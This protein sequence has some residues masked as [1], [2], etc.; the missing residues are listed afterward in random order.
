MAGM[1]RSWLC[2]AALIS[3]AAGPGCFLGSRPFDISPDL[4]NGARLPPTADATAGLTVAL[5][6]GP[7]QLYVVSL[8]AGVWHAASGGS[9][10][11]TLHGPTFAASV[12]ADP[13]IPGHI[14]AGERNPDTA[15]RVGLWESQDGGASWSFRLN[16]L[17]FP[18]CAAAQSAAIPAI[19]VGDAGVYVA[20]PC[21]VAIRTLLDPPNHF[22]LH[23]QTT[24]VGSVRAF[25]TSRVNGT[26]R[27]WARTAGAVLFSDDLGSSWTTMPIPI[28]TADGWDT[29]QSL[30]QPGDPRD[31]YSIAA[32]G[33]VAFFPFLRGARTIQANVTADEC[34]PQAPGTNHKNT[35]LYARGAER[36]FKV[37]VL[38]SCDGS[39]L[40]GRRFARSLLVSPQAQIAR[41]GHEARVFFDDAQ[42]LFEATRQDA[43]GLL[44]WNQISVAGVHSDH[45]DLAANAAGDLVLASDGGVQT[46]PAGQSGWVAWNGGLHTQHINTFTVLE[47][48]GHDA[49]NL[50]VATADNGSWERSAA[51]FSAPNTGWSVSFGG[52]DINWTMGDQR[53]Y[54]FAVSL[55]NAVTALGT[56]FSTRFTVVPDCVPEI[57]NS[58]V[59]CGGK[60]PVGPLDFNLIQTLA[61]EPPSLAGDAYLLVQLPLRVIRQVPGS[62]PTIFPAAGVLGSGTGKVLL[63]NR[64]YTG[65]ADT[66]HAWTD[67]NVEDPGRPPPPGL[68]QVFASGGHTHTRYWGLDFAQG[69]LYRNTPGM[70]WTPVDVHQEKVLAVYLN[71]YDPQHLF[72]MTPNQVYVTV[73]GGAT[74]PPDDALKQLITSSLTYPLTAPDSDG[75]NALQNGGSGPQGT[76]AVMSSRANAFAT[77]SQIAFRP[78]HPHQVMVAAPQGGAFY[79]DDDRRIWRS[80]SDDLPLN[81]A[82]VTGVA[83]DDQS[84][85]VG[86]EGRGLFSIR[87]VAA[88]RLG[89][90]IERP[91]AQMAPRILGTARAADGT[92][93]AGGTVDVVVLPPGG[94]DES[95]ATV[96]T[97]AAGQ[98]G[99][100]ASLPLPQGATV[101]LSVHSGRRTSAARMTYTR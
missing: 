23:P 17:T 80:I 56:N 55:R 29:N 24:G 47:H 84:G 5:S 6:Q 73:D 62:P 20:T 10:Q 18:A 92:P 61:G 4:L 91:S 22:V 49:P 85:Y 14:F 7:D 53:N 58:V 86:T 12:A 9:W 2:V 31:Y 39:G 79:A 52:Q 95:F 87:N 60:A 15:G 66:T 34:L 21:G 50:L 101:Y 28:L 71:P 89:T 83:L 93:V 51:D 11:Q 63:R 74:F 67:W 90:W 57:D 19:L 81:G 75:N 32:F 26:L 46:R 38:P 13:Q 30:T 59:A 16:P 72:A 100:P 48:F 96:T 45:W 1:W 69:V 97:D 37:Q 76:G 41:L 40:G 88:A 64:F 99:A 82:W 25:A 65:G 98:I 70:G 77:I 35:L 27:I 3:S 68:S 43:N 33:D 42:D 36:D 78:S 44:F 8:N 54:A 94:G